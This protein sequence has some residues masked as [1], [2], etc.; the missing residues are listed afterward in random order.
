MP[1]SIGENCLA[2]D[3]SKRE[4]GKNTNNNKGEGGVGE[5]QFEIFTFC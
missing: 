1:N 4:L 3:K 5:I 2:A